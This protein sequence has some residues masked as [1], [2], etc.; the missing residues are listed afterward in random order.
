[1]KKNRIKLF[2]ASVLSFSLLF[3]NVAMASEENNITIE[4]NA[5][6][7]V[8]IPDKEKFLVKENMLPGDEANGTIVLDNHYDYPY[9]IYLRAEDYEHNTD[10]S[11]VNKLNLKLDLDGNE[12]YN[13]NLHGDDGLSQ[14]VELGTIEPGETKTI[15]ANVTLDGE[16]TGNEYK[17]C[18][19]SCK[20]IFTA[21]RT[22]E[23]S[24]DPDVPDE[25]DV[26]DDPPATKTPSNPSDISEDKNIPEESSTDVKPLK[27]ISA[28][29][30]YVKTNDGAKIAL[31]FI[32]LAASGSVIIITMKKRGGKIENK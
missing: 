7:L 30:N 16:S 28:L 10:I 13:G 29:K 8:T 31:L 25:P 14:N 5:R 12:F 26:P 3:T 24:G 18:Y 15:K 22:E 6:G 21:V 9:T 11:F 17:N 20:W 1:M 4:G 32:M 19:A 23:P 27:L 2:V